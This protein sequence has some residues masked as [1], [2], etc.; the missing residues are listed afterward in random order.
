MSFYMTTLMHGRK[1]AKCHEFV[2]HA[3]KH[4]NMVAIHT[5]HSKLV[6]TDFQMFSNLY[7]Y[8][9]ILV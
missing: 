4:T 8:S 9:T 6:L 3:N 2:R 1:I 7:L 5:L